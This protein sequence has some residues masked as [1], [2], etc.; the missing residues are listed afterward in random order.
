MRR[1]NSRFLVLAVTGIIL[2][3]LLAGCTGLQVPGKKTVYIVYGSEKGDLSYTDS[4]YA[5]LQRAE[6]EMGVRTRE[7]TPTDYQEIPAL[8][9][10]TPDAEKPGLIITV[11]FQYADFSR[12]IAA[13]HP[14]IGVLAIDQA[15]NGTD[16]LQVYE[17]T[18]YGDSYLAGALAASATRTGR[19]GIIMGM[20][21]EL[22]DTFIQG[23]RDGARAVNASIVV[24]PAYVHEDSV[25]GFTD[26]ERAESI[27]EAMYRNGTDVIFVGA[28]ISNTGVFS[29]ATTT[30]GRYVIGTDADQSPL[31]PGFILASAMKRVDRVVYSGISAYANGTF[32]GGNRVAGL[33]EGVTGIVYNPEFAYYEKTVSAWERAAETGEQEFLLNRSGK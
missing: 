8:L 14:E 20:K 17:I 30:P 1:H 28:G 15:G 13:Q 24:D 18:S 25:T 29:A 9:N 5:G 11:G 33:K 31:G 12:T 27:A 10:A 7:F 4:A 6:Q 3:L 2:F 21:T 23:Y 32:A 26:P 16:N 22:L 19:I